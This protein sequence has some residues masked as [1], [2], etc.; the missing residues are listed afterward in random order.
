MRYQSLIFYVFMQTHW[1]NIVYICRLALAAVIGNSSMLSTCWLLNADCR[2]TFTLYCVS[3]NRSALRAQKFA[4]DFSIALTKFS[5][6]RCDR[7]QSIIDNASRR[8]VQRRLVSGGIRF[9]EFVTTYFDF[10]LRKISSRL[11]GH[12][13]LFF[14]FTTLF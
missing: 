14:N 11:T 10:S 2:S 9:A 1:Y 3:S 8:T 6:N 5:W 13:I 4:L 12:L 7:P